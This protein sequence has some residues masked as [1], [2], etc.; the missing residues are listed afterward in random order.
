M[1]R[2]RALRL[3][4]FLLVGGACLAF[5][6]WKSSDRSANANHAWRISQGVGYQQ[7]TVS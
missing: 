3:I 5:A 1:T 4:M 7:I 6:M 2:V